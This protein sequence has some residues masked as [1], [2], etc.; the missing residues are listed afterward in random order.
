MWSRKGAPVILSERLDPLLSANQ[1]D[2]NPVADVIRHEVARHMACGGLP[3][4]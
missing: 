3:E 1:V 2:A 4:F